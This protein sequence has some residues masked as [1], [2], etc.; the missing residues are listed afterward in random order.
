M[1]LCDGRKNEF[2]D[3]SAFREEII[4]PTRNRRLIR[5]LSDQGFQ[6]AIGQ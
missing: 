4:V 5:K 6:L 2:V 3:K 1:C